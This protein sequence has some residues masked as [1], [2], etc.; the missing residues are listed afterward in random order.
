LSAALAA[1]PQDELP[2]SPAL[3]E[4]ML[5]NVVKAARAHQLYLQNNPMHA[6]AIELAKASF[7]P[8]WEHAGSIELAVHETELTWHGRAVLSDAEKSGDGLPWLL[9]KDGVRHLLI[10]EGFEQEL[11]AFLDILQRVRRAAPDE[12]DLL[13]LL[14]ERDFAA[15]RYQYVELPVEGAVPL[16]SGGVRA[17]DGPTSWDVADEREDAAGHAGVVSMDAFD[18]TLYFLDE[19]EVEYLQGEVAREY[20]S[21]LRQ[22]IVAIVL[23]VFERQEEAAVRDEICTVL[24]SLMLHLLSAGEFRTVAYLLREAS[25]AAGR[26]ASLQAA[27]RERLAALALR[28]SSAEALSQLLQALDGATEL[29]S[30][31]DLS[32]LFGQLQ[33]SA[34][35]TAIAWLG[36]LQNPSLKTLLEGSVE[37]MA[38]SNTAELVRLI[39]DSDRQVALAA[40]RRAAALKSPA[41]VPAL[42]RLLAE[43]DAEVRL[44][45]VQ[46][47]GEIGSAGALQ[48]LERA[49]EDAER[50]VRVAAARAITARAYR[51]ALA[52]V[53]TAVKG[54]AIR[55]ADLTEQMAFFEA[56]GALCGDGGVA[57]LDAVLNGKGFLGRREEPQMR[58]CAA[59][60]LGRVGT[61]RALESLRRSSDD[62]E[63]VVR[64][65]VN[66]ALR[67]GAA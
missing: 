56:Y 63:V 41:A 40:V 44:A 20:A 46:A 10:S 8:L 53:E 17:D 37:R 14:W 42:T 23:D 28:V 49:V 60:A 34:L 54:K 3:V 9:Y 66:R 29:P 33:S 47:L 4:E 36:R 64:S 48:S 45:G 15:L 7:A 1:P 24:D 21:D 52:R 32:E 65:A 13:T 6:R 35:R 50:E 62:K 58:A 57:L 26:T 12:D 5:R 30:Q 31:A 51:P 59:V 2:C 22:N 19:Q 16:G 67:G 61:A 18:S 55:D 38:A 43:R 25:A 39:S 27:H 11:V